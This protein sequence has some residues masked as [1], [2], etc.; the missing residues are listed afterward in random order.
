M[1]VVGS[2]YNAPQLRIDS[3]KPTLLATAAQQFSSSTGTIAANTWSYIGVTYSAS[4]VFTYYING[5][6]AGSGTV[7]RTFTFTSNYI[8]RT[9]TASENFVGS[10]DG[11][12]MYNRIL[13]PA[14]MAS[15]YASTPQ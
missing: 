10:I 9:S 6:A 15:L 4:G 11:V 3:G 2:G 12:R 14:E 5:V 1:T 8:G 7:A 13:S